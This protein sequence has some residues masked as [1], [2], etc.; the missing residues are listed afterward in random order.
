[1]KVKPKSGR[2]R[3]HKELGDLMTDGTLKIKLQSAPEDGKA[4][5]ELIKLL[6]DF[7]EVKEQNVIILSGKTSRQ[8]LIEIHPSL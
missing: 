3:A 2:Q 4:N 8:K 7:F 5:K 6:S 1:M